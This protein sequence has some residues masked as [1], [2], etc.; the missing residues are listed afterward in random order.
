MNINTTKS[1]YIACYECGKIISDKA[2]M[3][4]P[5][6]CSLGLAY[7]KS[8]HPACYAKAE[9]RAEKELAA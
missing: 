8:Y 5:S 7:P 1:M 9:A 4:N 6:N 2:V 3:T